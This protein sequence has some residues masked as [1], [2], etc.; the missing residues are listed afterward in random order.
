[1]PPVFNRLPRHFVPRNDDGGIHS[2]LYLI[3]LEC[4]EL[5]NFHKS[6]KREIDQMIITLQRTTIILIALMLFGAG[7]AGAQSSTPREE[8]WVTDGTVNAIVRTA[9]TVYLVN[10]VRRRIE[11]TWVS[12]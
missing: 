4:T 1:M 12:G 6:K 9:D 5:N 7:Q 11:V 3:D 10:S 8:T 2:Q